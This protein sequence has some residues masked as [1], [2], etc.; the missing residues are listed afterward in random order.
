M[1]AVFC[2]VALSLI[3]LA[4]KLAF[5]ADLSLPGLADSDRSAS[6]VTRLTG[7]RTD[8]DQLV[9]I[10]R[11]GYN[12]RELAQTLPL[13]EPWPAGGAE[14]DKA[15]RRAGLDP[16]ASPKTL[17]VPSQ[18]CG[19]VYLVAQDRLSNL[20]YPIDCGSEG[21]ALIDPT[22]DSEFERTLA[23]VEACRRTP[24]R[25]PLG[26]LMTRRISLVKVTAKRGTR[27]D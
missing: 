25:D 7:I 18:I 6:R 3:A 20:A 26:L 23:N 8:E 12:R 16:H 1:R 19:D 2:V 22:L 4:S 14:M 9:A 5:A 27:R 24:K 11:G 13:D 21:A 17:P 15:L 10:D